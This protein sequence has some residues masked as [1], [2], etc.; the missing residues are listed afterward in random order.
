[1]G[2]VM[3]DIEHLIHILGS[4]TT[5]ITQ[6]PMIRTRKMC[7]ESPHLMASWN[8]CVISP[9]WRKRTGVFVNNISFLCDVRWLSF[10]PRRSST[11]LT[12]VNWD[13]MV[14]AR[15]TSISQSWTWFSHPSAAFFFQKHEA[16]NG[17]PCHIVKQRIDPETLGKSVA[18]LTWSEDD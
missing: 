6:C 8:S 3:N 15:V 16:D 10:I 1:M 14:L 17:G 2:K 9:S 13:C 7:L 5:S 11:T 18:K 12:F 4:P